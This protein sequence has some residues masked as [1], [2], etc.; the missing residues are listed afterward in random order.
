MTG[1]VYDRP[2][3]AKSPAGGCAIAEPTPNRKQLVFTAVD[4]LKGRVRELARFDTDPASEAKY[5][6]DLSPD[7]SR[8]AILKYSGGQI[9]I[10]PLNGQAPQEIVVK[11]WNNLLSVNW[12]ADGKGLF[13]SSA[14]QGGSVLLRVDLQGHAHV[15]WEQKGSIARW[16][17]YGLGGPTAPWAVPSP[18]GRHLAIYDWQLSAN[19]WMMENF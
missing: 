11:G 17:F 4:P 18:D 12:M 6:W 9:H 3:C 2:V 19:M 8:I 5:V 13:A 10:L 1:H 7:S 16:S 15:L 14:A